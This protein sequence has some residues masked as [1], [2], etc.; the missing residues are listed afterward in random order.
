MKKIISILAV[1]LCAGAVSAQVRGL[2]AD[3]TLTKTTPGKGAPEK[4]TGKIYY[5]APGSLALHYAAPSTNLVIIDGTAVFTRQD[6]RERRFDTEKNAPMRGMSETLINCVKGETAKVAE[7]ND[8]D[9]LVQKFARS[10]DVTITARKK[11]AR[12]YS[13]I[14]LSYRKSDGLLQS[15]TLTEFNGVVSEYRMTAFKPDA[16]LPSDAFT[17]PAKSSRPE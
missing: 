1:L 4:S 11:S 3:F 12:G 15:M 7:S 10:T 8:A 6:G 16:P 5:A 2:E 9:I 13:C 14:R 17:I